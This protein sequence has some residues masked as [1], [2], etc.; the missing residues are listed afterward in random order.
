[1]TIKGRSSSSSLPICLPNSN[2]SINQP[3]GKYY[4]S[5]RDLQGDAPNGLP[6]TPR[7]RRCS[8]GFPRDK[9]ARQ[10]AGGGTRG[11]RRAGSS[12]QPGLG[13]GSWVAGR[14]WPTGSRCPGRPHAPHAAQEGDK[15]GSSLRGPSS[16]SHSPGGRAG[17]GA[18][19]T[20]HMQLRGQDGCRPGS[21]HARPTLWLPTAVTPP[22]APGS[23]AKFPDGRQ[24]ELSPR[25]DQRCNPQA[26]VFPLPS[27]P[28]FVPQ[29]SGCWEPAVGPKPSTPRHPLPHPA[30]ASTPA[31]SRSRRVTEE[32]RRPSTSQVAN[33]F[34]SNARR[35]LQSSARCQSDTFTGSRTQSSLFP[36]AR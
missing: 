6:F 28:R 2:Q 12:A 31:E 9:E 30:P 36:H 25:I 19:A 7:R 32:A 24:P 16:I 21:E 22:G 15:P 17:D 1:M 29:R 8:C 5:W 20:A 13:P 4:V 23:K 11:L 3:I 33:G 18:G 10:V 27:G 14:W 35:E 26:R 34:A